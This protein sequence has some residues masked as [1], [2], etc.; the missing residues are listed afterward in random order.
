MQ[1]SRFLQPVASCST[2]IE[3]LF[4]HNFLP[5]AHVVSCGTML[6]TRGSA[7]NASTLAAAQTSDTCSHQRCVPRYHNHALTA[8]EAAGALHQPL[9]AC[10]TMGQLNRSSVHGMQLLDAFAHVQI[11]GGH[12]RHAV[13]ALSLTCAVHQ[14]QIIYARSGL[15]GVAT[16]SAAESLN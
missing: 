7:A 1:T 8:G 6:S 11:S 9:L 12:P 15:S 13:N 10:S 16:L 2:R 4:K 14:H 3:L 5:W